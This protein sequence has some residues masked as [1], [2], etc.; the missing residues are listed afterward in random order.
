M[1]LIVLLKKKSSSNLGTGKFVLLELLTFICTAEQPGEKK[2][3]PYSWGA[4]G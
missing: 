1:L 3:V 4:V 2:K